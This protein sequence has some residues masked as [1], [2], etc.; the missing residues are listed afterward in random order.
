MGPLCWYGG[1]AAH[2]FAGDPVL[3]QSLWVLLDTVIGWAGVGGIPPS[4]A[5]CLLGSVQVHALD[6][7]RGKSRY[8]RAQR[9]PVPDYAGSVGCVESSEGSAGS[10][11]SEH[12]SGLLRGRCEAVDSGVTRVRRLRVPRGAGMG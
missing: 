6:A 4:P 3:E 7:T 10:S 1:V 9:E 5:P 2:A 11:Q 12:E 8:H